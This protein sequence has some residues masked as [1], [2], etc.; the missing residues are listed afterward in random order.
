MKIKILLSILLSLLVP[1]LTSGQ[2]ID[3]SANT[4]FKVGDTFIAKNIYFETSKSQVVDSSSTG[5]ENLKQVLLRNPSMNVEIQIRLDAGYAEDNDSKLSKKR[6]Y[7]LQSKLISMGIKKSRIKTKPY[8]IGFCP[9]R[10][11]VEND[12]FPGYVV[13]VIVLEI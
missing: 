8:M 11:E 3:L 7:S 10:L 2:Y 1:M 5:L 6:G 13:A 12:P 4:V 9:S